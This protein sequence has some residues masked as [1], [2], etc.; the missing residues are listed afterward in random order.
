MTLPIWPPTGLHITV[1]PLTPEAPLPLFLSLDIFKSL[2]VRTSK[3]AKSQVKVLDTEL[4]DLS[5]IPET[6]RMGGER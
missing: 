1:S 3:L 2:G 5:S 6:P 4:E